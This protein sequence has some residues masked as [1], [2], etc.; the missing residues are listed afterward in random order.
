[1]KIPSHQLEAFVVVA[2]TGH[3]T[4]AAKKLNV[5]QSAL[6]QRILNLESFLQTSLFIRERSGLRLT[7]K[8]EELLRYCHIQQQL[9][10]EFISELNEPTSLLFKPTLRIATFSSIARSLLIPAVS[11]LIQ[12]NQIQF[13]LFTRELGEL[14]A[15]L[16]SAEVDYLIIDQ[17]SENQTIE[18]L[19]L[20][21]EENVMICAA[22]QKRQPVQWIID[23]D[24]LDDVSMKYQRINKISSKKV[25]KRYLDD[26]YGLI[27]GV[28]NG[29]G[30]AI[31][32]LHLIRK[33]D[34]LD[35]VNAEKILYTEVWL[36]FY[37]QPYYTKLHEKV[38]SAMKNYFGKKLVQQKSS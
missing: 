3:F 4:K 1:M 13:H 29:L 19:F 6:S 14:Q 33:D 23:H 37:Q 22:G 9:E 17:K 36:H 32:P 20:G 35:I 16:S 34:D 11:D 7:A 26:V 28:R 15:M 27:D 12:A 30:T 2:Q 24:E 25:N 10:N 38:L 5:T 21:Y 8:G 18:S 31:V